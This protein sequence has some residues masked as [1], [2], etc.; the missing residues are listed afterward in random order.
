M[1]CDALLGDP[2]ISNALGGM[3]ASGA[4]AS[5]VD[6]PL[7]VQGPVTVSATNAEL[8]NATVTNTTDATALGLPTSSGSQPPSG[9]GLGLVIAM[10]RVSGAAEA[11]ISVT[12]S[13]P[14]DVSAVRE[15]PATMVLTQSPQTLSAMPPPKV[16]SAER[17]IV[18]E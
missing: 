14:P 9:F 11:V 15:R 1:R 5:I 4:T 8:I 16:A 12:H 7:T 10:N 13:T 2:L 17:V 6:T 18:P 3:V